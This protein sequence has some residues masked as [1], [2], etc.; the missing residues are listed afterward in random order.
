[1]RFDLSG[2]DRHLSENDQ[3]TKPKGFA[4]YVLPEREI[5]NNK[6]I[7]NWYITECKL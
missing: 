5:T 7:Y 2:M 6:K 4:L 1:M 3:S